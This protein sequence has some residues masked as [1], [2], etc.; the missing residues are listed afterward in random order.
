[1]WLLIKFSWY[2]ISLRHNSWSL[3][4]FKFAWFSYIGLIWS[5]KL[6]VSKKWYSLNLLKGSDDLT[7]K[8]VSFFPLYPTSSFFFLLLD[9]YDSQFST[10]SMISDDIIPAS[11]L[12]PLLNKSL[13]WMSHLNL[14]IGM[15]PYVYI[16]KK[17]PLQLQL[18]FSTNNN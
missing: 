9:R 13:Q 11:S 7:E 2:E 3:C 10:F 14:L 18:Y 8:T 17:R 6:V 1:M 4:C 16:H 5:T 15:E 12:L